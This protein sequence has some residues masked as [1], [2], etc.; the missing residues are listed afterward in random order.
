MAT[1]VASFVWAMAEYITRGK[2]SVLGFC[3][4]AVAGLVVI[5]PAC[6]FVDS[7]GAI[8]I[9]I[10][11]GLVPYFA[12]WKVKSWFGYDDALDTF[13]VHAIGG[14]IGAF[15]T[16][17]LATAHSGNTNITDAGAAAKAN[18]LAKLVASGGLWVEQVKA[19]AITL[20]LAVVGTLVI[21]YAVKA[22][23]G[24]RPTEETELAG[25]DIS[26]HGE[27]G[28]HGESGGHIITGHPAIPATAG[29]PA[30]ATAKAM[31]S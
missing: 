3:S 16:G 8:I 20:A 30:A 18:G 27:E 19:I 26:E 4:G 11:A 24:L 2:P 15:L 9:G 23:M 10:A 5:T 31:A 22:V 12:C 29:H 1:A 28:Y 21:A 13:G 25:L 17:I 14:T 7:N 6:G